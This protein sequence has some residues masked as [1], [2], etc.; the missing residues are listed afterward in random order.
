MA[1]V[2]SYC[3]WNSTSTASLTFYNVYSKIMQCYLMIFVLQFNALHLHLVLSQCQLKTQWNVKSQRGLVSHICC[4]YRNPRYIQFNKNL[5]PHI[6]YHQYRLFSTRF[7]CRFSRAAR[8]HFNEFLSQKI[9]LIL[10]R[11]SFSLVILN[12]R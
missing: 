1:S 8:I 6:S 2:T 7:P 11:C 9:G 4:K 10:H 5:C 3:G 12:S